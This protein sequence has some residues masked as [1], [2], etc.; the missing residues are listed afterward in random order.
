MITVIA[1]SASVD[2]TYVVDELLPGAVHRPGSVHRV[3]GGK[4]L[5]AARAAAAMGADVSAVAVLGG[6]TGEVIA[7]ELGGAG[8]D[9]HTVDGSEETRMCISIAS[10]A[11]GRMTE[12]YEQAPPVSGEEWRSIG[13]VIRQLGPERPGWLAVSGSVPANLATVVLAE[14]VKL[15]MELGLSVAIDTHGPSLCR[16]VNAGPTLIKVNRA[17]AAALLGRDAVGN[18]R[19]FAAAIQERTRGVVVVTD[20]IAGSVATDGRE[21]WQVSPSVVTGNFPVGSG[22]SFL[23]GMLV[24]FDSGGGL[25]DALRLGAGCATA[26]ALVPGAARFDPSEARSIATAL[27]LTRLW[28]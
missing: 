21:S 3:A 22:D 17:E 25:A 12:V 23:G 14:L 20:G 28:N 27:D 7:R 9:L 24:A 2:V 16:A 8:V 10:L 1:L 6:V 18:T 11:D 5:N 19:L 15:G 13:D 4:S 26:N